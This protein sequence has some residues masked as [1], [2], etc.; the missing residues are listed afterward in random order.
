M[1]EPAVW[2]IIGLTV[3]IVVWGVVSWYI[4]NIRGR[5]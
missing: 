4:D 5:G 3:G 2:A 1:S